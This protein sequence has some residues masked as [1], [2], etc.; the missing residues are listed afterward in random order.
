MS[1]TM[2]KI[3]TIFAAAVMVGA[4]LTGA[5]AADLKNLPAPFVSDG[6]ADV[7]IVVGARAATADVLGSIDIAS[8]LQAKAVTTTTVNVGGSRSSSVSDGYKL[9]KSGNALLLGGNLNAIDS[10]IDDKD[11][12]D[13]LADG[14]IED[15]DDNDELEYDQ[16]IVPGADITVQYDNDDSDM[17]DPVLY[18]D[19][20]TAADVLW[21]YNASLKGGA[22]V[23]LA[24]LDDSETVVMMG[25]TFTFAP[26]NTATSEITLFG[27]DDTEYLNLNEPKTFTVDGKAY[28]V[29]VTGGNSDATPAEIIVA[30]NGVSKTVSE[31][32]SETINGLEIFAKDVFVT[33]IPTLSAAATLFIGSN[34]I[35][36]PAAAANPTWT[37]VEIG[38]E[39][40]NGLESK[41]YATTD[42]NDVTAFAFRY[43]PTDLANDISGF[44]ETNWL[45]AGQSITDPLFGAFEVLFNGGNYALDDEAKTP[46]KVTGG[47]NELT[48][49]FVNEDGDAISF[50][51]FIL[52]G[53]NI[54]LRNTTEGDGWVGAIAAANALGDGDIFAV[55]EGTATSMTTS[56]FEVTGF[57][58][59]SS[60]DVV[61]LKN[62]GTGQTE[63]YAN[64]DE[65]VDGVTIDALTA[66][67]SFSLS[68][69]TVDILYTDGGLNTIDLSDPSVGGTAVDINITEGDLDQVTTAGVFALNLS[70]DATDAEFDVSLFVAAGTTDGDSDDGNNFEY[71]LSEFGTYIVSEI[72]ESNYVQLYMPIDKD[73]EVHYEVFFAPTDATVTTTGGSSVTTTT[74]NPIA[75]GAAVLDTSVNLA[76]ESKNLIVVGGPCAN[77]VAAALLQTA[78]DSCAAG[79]TPGKAIIQL[80]DTPA[81]K[82]AMLVAGY[83]ATE[84]QAASRAVA[85]MDSRLTGK[86]VTL[87]VTNTNDFTISSSQ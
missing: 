3:G 51:P 27:S 74:V 11:L 36:L 45:E 24:T 66:G 17:D 76:T 44:D 57:T 83:E 61:R 31:G 54:E 25:K 82:V 85:L 60:V 23:D 62:L 32:D 19:L 41:V 71:T 10:N 18:L 78:A 50:A 43:K 87:T 29:E 22:T 70:K 73:A 7:A 20:D 37:D 58:T 49:E 15:A 67:D 46:I 33:N 63:T 5:I 65:L 14:V 79:F 4:T 47:D 16:T 56:V 77:S 38:G 12:P 6:R 2:K 48:L 39:T 75:V 68:D 55:E 59:E 81:N 21:T 53:S 13:L 72:D 80:F 28:K 34:E 35:V 64:G 52:D 8:A 86:S 26:T 1:K 30:V 9:E 40:I 84:T 69:A 42:N